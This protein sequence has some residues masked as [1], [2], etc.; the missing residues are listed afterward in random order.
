LPGLEHRFWGSGGLDDCQRGSGEEKATRGKQQTTGD[1]AVTVC[2]VGVRHHEQ[3]RIWRVC[4]RGT[5]ILL[6]AVAQ[7]KVLLRALLTGNPGKRLC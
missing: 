5:V 6:Q 4:V 2:L 1:M 7:K 3:K